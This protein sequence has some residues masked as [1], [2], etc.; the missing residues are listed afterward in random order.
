[1]SATP[2]PIPTP[3]IDPLKLVPVVPSIGTMPISLTVSSPDNRTGRLGSLADHVP[4]ALN[5]P[6]ATTSR[7]LTRCAQSLTVTGVLLIVT[8]PPPGAATRVWMRM[9]PRRLQL[10]TNPLCACTG[11]EI[12]STI[13]AQNMVGRPAAADETGE[14]ARSA[15][16]MT[17]LSSPASVG[18]TAAMV[19]GG[20][21]VG[22]TGEDGIEPPPP[23]PPPQDQ[24]RDRTSRHRKGDGFLMVCEA[25]WPRR[26]LP[27][28]G[29]TAQQRSF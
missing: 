21:G 25:Q 24:D 12:D 16:I 20:V 22:A 10:A 28:T 13:A 19:S 5:E 4:V 6:L 15:A 1:V 17:V 3:P 29:N 23:F 18:A 14:P 7:P 9:L 8:R 27:A 26:V 2:V 11:T